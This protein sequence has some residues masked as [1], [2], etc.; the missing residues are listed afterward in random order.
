[1]DGRWPED[2]HR[3]RASEFRGLHMEQRHEPHPPYGG[4]AAHQP[5]HHS[6]S[7]HDSRSHAPSSASRLPPPPIRSHADSDAY[8]QRSNE[9]RLS[10][11]PGSQG[12]E[13]RP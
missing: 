5:M 13:R 7:H 2:E 3:M 10:P 9:R 8:A 4:S 1:M 11:R 12:A 6:H